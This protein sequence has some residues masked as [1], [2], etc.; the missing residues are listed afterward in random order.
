MTFGEFIKMF[1][2]TIIV[3]NL[4]IFITIFAVL[5]VV[6]IA[7]LLMRPYRLWYWK[8]NKNKEEINAELGKL[9]EA[10]KNIEVMVSGSEAKECAGSGKGEV[11]AENTESSHAALKNEKDEEPLP[12]NGEASSTSF[13]GGRDRI[14][15][16]GYDTDKQGRIYTEEEIT[17]LIKD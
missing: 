4:N 10:V 3:E 6:L 9:C 13:S 16:R 11:N 1:Y 14:F 2:R 12:E 7:A 17:K 15:L 5:T 8:V